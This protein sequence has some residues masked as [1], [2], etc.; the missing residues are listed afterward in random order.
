MKLPVN[1]KIREGILKLEKKW[2]ELFDENSLYKSL[3]CLQIIEELTFSEENKNWIKKMQSSQALAFFLEVYTKQ[4]FENYTNNISKK[5]IATLLKIVN[6][7]VELWKFPENYQKNNEKMK[8]IS[9]KLLESLSKIS[10]FTLLREKNNLE[11]CQYEK[12]NY[13]NKVNERNENKEEVKPPEFWVV[14]ADILS[15]C[16]EL[17]LGV[18]KSCPELIDL[19]YNY[20]NLEEFLTI[21]LIKTDNFLLKKRMQEYL[22]KL[23]KSN[24]SSSQE[25]FLPIFFKKLF[26][27]AMQ[28]KEN[29]EVF[30]EVL[31]TNLS[32]LKPKKLSFTNKSKNL[33]VNLEETL[34]SLLQIIKSNT[35]TER[36]HNDQ[37]NILIGVL[38]LLKALLV[39][40]PHKIPEIAQTKGLLQEILGPCLFETPRKSIKSDLYPKCKG[41]ASRNAAFELLLVLILGE[42]KYLKPVVGY[43]SPMLKKAEWR[44][45]SYSDWNILPK[46]NEK[47]STGYVGLKNLGC[48]KLIILI[49]Y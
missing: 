22:K 42:V 44:T 31:Q 48:S 15:G 6:F 20:P 5:Y 4:P 38:A 47:S 35:F 10:E 12:E 3:Y 18:L 17:F 1:E 41:F 46:I 32:F 45:K 27:L 30:F 23:F 36:N 13:F 37:D 7:Y 11:N 29:S 16:F 28:N 21:S 34:D 14:E 8:Q 19:L 24:I 25:F 9:T 33:E 49:F 43:L 40:M 2:E 39:H 26:P